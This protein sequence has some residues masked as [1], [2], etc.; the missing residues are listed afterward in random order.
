M[1]AP[2][3]AYPASII[4]GDVSRAMRGRGSA[5]SPSQTASTGGPNFRN[6]AEMRKSGFIFLPFV[7]TSVNVARARPASLLVYFALSSP[8][9]CSTGFST[10]SGK[11]VSARSKPRRSVRTCTIILE[12]PCCDKEAAVTRW[13]NDFRRECTSTRC[14]RRRLLFDIDV[15]TIYAIFYAF[16]IYCVS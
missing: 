2:L 13:N 11:D 10:K 15:A 6:T 5:E 4:Y 9:F 16:M 14:A 1:F 3:E 8:L 7:F 12:Y